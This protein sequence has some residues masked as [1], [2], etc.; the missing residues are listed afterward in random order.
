MRACWLGGDADADGDVEQLL[1]GGDRQRGTPAACARRAR[2]RRCSTSD[3]RRTSTANS[4]PP[5]RATTSLVADGAHQP[6]GDAAQQLVA[7]RVA[8]R[9]VDA[10]EVVEVDEHHGDLAGG[11]RLE[12]LAHLLAEQRA[13]GEPG[14][15]VVVGLVLELVLQVAQLG[16]G[17]LE[18]VELQRGARVGGQRLEQRAVAVGEAA[19]EAEAVGEHDR[20]DHAVLAA[21]HAEHRR[22]G[23]RAPRG[24]RSSVAG[25]G[26]SSATAPSE[27]AAQARSAAAA[28][29]STRRH[30][31]A[32]GARAEAGAQRRAAVGGEEDDLGLLGAEGLERALEQALERDRDLGRLRQ[33]PVGLVEELDLLV[34][35]ALVDVG[36]VAEEGDRRSGSAAAARPRAARSRGC[37]QTSAIA[38]P[39]SVTT[40]SMPN[41]CAHLVARDVALG[42]HDRGEDLRRSS[43]RRRAAW[44]RA[45][46]PT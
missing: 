25:N 27:P 30:R 37:A 34:A 7:D 6:G 2:R 39:V 32:G 10:L 42:Q 35:L 5:R 3:G 31:L 15:R 46:R 18:A 28:A 1:A 8:E 13:V 4:S 9:V 45:R 11:A 33:R 24:R 12:R 19:R 16:D 26:A 36:A 23:R 29:A 41:I 22:G 44:R 38:V 20:A 17:L 14:Q 21:Q 43:A 40:K